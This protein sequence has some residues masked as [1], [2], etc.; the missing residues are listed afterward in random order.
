VNGDDW[1]RRAELA[2]LLRA[3]RARLARPPVPGTRRIGMRQEDVAGVAGISV[4]AYGDFERGEYV[5][6]AQVVDQISSALQMSAAERSALHVLATGQD[7]PRPLAR[8]EHSLRGEQVQALRDLVS[9][10]P[11][12]AAMTDETW[13]VL[14]YN[15]DM[16]ARSGGW[17]DSVP[18][19]DRHLVAYLFTSH[20]EASLGDIKAVRRATIARLRYQYVRNLSSPGFTAII[21]RLLKNSPAAA[22]LWSKGELAFSPHLY[23]VTIRRSGLGPVRGNVLFSPVTPQVWTWTMIVP[24]AARPS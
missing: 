23:P 22:Q 11:Y 17:F 19:A 15:R 8:A 7:P 10:S 14:H 4:R 21:E 1:A 6:N 13:T 3:C 18:T 5:P 20:A 12:A 2:G 16:D 24:R 9:R